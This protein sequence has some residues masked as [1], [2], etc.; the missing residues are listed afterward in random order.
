[1]IIFILILLIFLLYFLIAIFLPK[2]T[3]IAA[4]LKMN[5]DL[6][7]TYET[8]KDFKNWKD[9]SIWNSDNT[10]NILLSEPS[11]QIGARYRWKSKIKELKDGLIILKSAREYHQLEFE[12]RYGKQRRGEI[13][14]NLEPDN[15]ISFVTCSITINNKTKIFARYFTW[16][17]RKSIH[18]N[19]QEVLVKIE[20]SMK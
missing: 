17:I 19:I 7:K 15:Q 3:T 10:L 16:L 14:F 6:T 8:L 13:L 9:W 1:M 4:S 20:E 2:T 5:T 18:K 12:W 11:D